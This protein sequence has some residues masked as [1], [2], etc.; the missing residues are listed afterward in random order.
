MNYE[1]RSNPIQDTA[2]NDADRL[3]NRSVTNR[4]GDTEGPEVTTVRITSSAGS[5]RTYGVDETIEVTVTFD[6]TVVIT[7]TP[8][9]TLDVGG[10]NRR[11]EYRSVSTRAVKFAYRVVTGDDDE[12]GMSIESNRLSRAGGTIRDGA[13]NNAVLGP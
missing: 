10:G 1:P 3:S 5:D 4:T 8:E 11:A 9:L 13:G 6:E 7:G 2:G 12:D